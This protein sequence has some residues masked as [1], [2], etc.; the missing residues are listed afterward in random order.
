LLETKCVYLVP[1]D[2]AKRFYVIDVVVS[3]PSAGKCTL[4]LENRESVKDGEAIDIALVEAAAWW[5]GMS[6]S[7]FSLKTNK[8]YLQSQYSN[9]S[10]FTNKI[11]NILIMVKNYGF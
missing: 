10:F 3:V 2:L 1:V 7:I 11:P 6:L 9:S 8:V 4:S 5:D